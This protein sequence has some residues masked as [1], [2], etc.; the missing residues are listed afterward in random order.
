[1]RF[2]AIINQL[3]S[4]GFNSIPIIA[5][6]SL[7]VG[8][9]MSLQ[10]TVIMRLF[11]AEGFVGATVA[12]TLGREL[13]P[14]MT[15]LML[16]AKNGSSMAAEFGSMKVTEQLD[17]LETMAV[18]PIHYFVVPRLLAAFLS[19][20]ILTALANIIGIL[21]AFFVAVSLQHV[22]P[23]LFWDKLYF[24][25]DPPDIYLGLIKASIMGIIVT[26]ICAF[27]GY[28][29]TNGAKGVGKATTSAVVFS[30]VSILIADYIMSQIMVKLFY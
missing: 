14:V 15:A 29:T 27:F 22:D 3:D 6:S 11:R 10:I 8:M 4:I 16:I 9:I 13:S 7:T 20:P 17:A 28:S 18:E 19:F 5:L 2:K 24:Y 25:V 21:G 23:A 1:L 30:S 12:M 26:L